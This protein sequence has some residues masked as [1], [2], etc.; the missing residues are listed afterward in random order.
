MRF[1]GRFCEMLFISVFLIMT[2][3]LIK[4]Y[5]LEE[6]NLHGKSFGG[7]VT[8][9]PCLR[10]LS[11]CGKVELSRY[12]SVSQVRMTISRFSVFFL[13]ACWFLKA[14]CFISA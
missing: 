7:L 4:I 3:N 13:V 8:S 14:S 12:N 10:F 5:L 6:H 9:R 1:Y 11:S 2:L